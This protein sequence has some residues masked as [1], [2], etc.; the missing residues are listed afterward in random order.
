MKRVCPK[1]YAAGVTLLDPAECESLVQYRITRSRWGRL[2]GTVSLRDCTKTI[3][4]EL[5]LPADAEGAGV[6]AI[7]KIDRAIAA[8]AD[9]RNAW[10]DALVAEERRKRLRRKK[11]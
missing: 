9:A 1:L 10:R 2:Y 7:E 4:W 5:S 8:L 6:P 3:A 11:K